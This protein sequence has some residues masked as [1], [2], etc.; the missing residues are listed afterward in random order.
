MVARLGDSV[1]FY[2]V[3]L[4]SIFAGGLAFAARLARSGKQVFLDV[5]LLDID[6]TVAG[7]VQQHRGDG[8][9]LRHHPR[10]SEGDARRG[11]GARRRAR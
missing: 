3:G 2:K 5:K 6:N 11:R 7:A 10:L 9:D 8:H 1:S 4:S